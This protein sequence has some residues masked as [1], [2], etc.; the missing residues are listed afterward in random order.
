MLSADEQSVFDA[1][2]EGLLGKYA[3]KDGP[4]SRYDREGQEYV[5]VCSWNTPPGAEPEVLHMTL[6]QA[7][8]AWSRNMMAY[9]DGKSKITWR[10][11][12]EADGQ[13][14]V[15]FLDVLNPE[16]SFNPYK[17]LYVA[18]TQYRIYSR[19]MAV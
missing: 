11:R 14:N 2:V 7:I 17:P 13:P 9:L 15:F 6:T 4:K 18:R 10:I 12:P 1:A 3:Q 8:E 19:L 5:E 16:F